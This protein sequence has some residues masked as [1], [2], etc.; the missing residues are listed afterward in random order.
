MPGLDAASTP[1]PGCAERAAGR[2]RRRGWPRS[3]AAPGE[4]AASAR[5]R[6]RRR[7][8][9]SSRGS[10]SSGRARRSASSD[11]YQSSSEVRLAAG[12]GPV[13]LGA[14]ERLLVLR[15]GHVGRPPAVRGELRLAARA[16]RLR[17]ERVGVVGEELPGRV[18]APLLAHE[19]HRRE[20]R[21]EDQARRAQ[22]CRRSDAGERGRRSGRRR[23]GCRPGRG[24]G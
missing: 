19:Q 1:V 23:R 12:L 4:P 13:E 20:R 24:P 7:G 15:V 11:R 10:V 16:H 5:P 17:E 14:Q 18:R 8:T 22:P 2:A 6:R 21:G 3:A 9:W